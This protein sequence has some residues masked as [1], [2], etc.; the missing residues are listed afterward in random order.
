MTGVLQSAQNGPQHDDAPEARDAVAR[1]HRLELHF[2]Q[3]QR[4]A[5]LGSWEW[6]IASDVV[7]W[8]DE[9]YRM[10]GIA[11]GEIHATYEALLGRIHPDDRDLVNDAV[12][13][14]FA[15]RGSFAFD[16][17]LV[18]ADGD[19]RWFHGRGSVIADEHGEPQRVDGVVIDITERKRS[20]LVLQE[21]ISN[22]SHA[23]RTP[24]AAIIQVAHVLGD[25]TLRSEDREA[26]MGAL[27]RQS[28][29]LHYLATNLFDLVALDKDT[30]SVMLG[31][32]VMLGPVPLA[33]GVLKAAASS[34][35][36]G[37]A[38]L[39]IDIDPDI[40]VLAEP[41][42]LER[43]FANL[44]TNAH[45]HGGPNVSVTANRQAD[46]VIVE[47]R[48]DGPG[49][50]AEYQQDLFEPF[51]KRRS[52]GKG[53]GLGLAIVHQLMVTFGGTISYHDAE[54]HGSVFTLRFAVP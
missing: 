25:T 46:E 13:Q 49:I 44:L 35:P 51:A 38:K 5:Q 3:I 27:G 34:P 48:D 8:S 14:A 54:P 52:D 43:L 40:A 2:A 30:P 11:P 37:D 22:A 45:T 36:A 31:L 53:S 50:P 28:Q 33:D 41:I 21:F 16:H 6:D 39:R 1:L 24:A 19:V 12:R 15:D 10:C 47:V 7:T 29:R 23:L 18:R 32:S 9:L 4:L 20:E 26:A 17:R 42:E